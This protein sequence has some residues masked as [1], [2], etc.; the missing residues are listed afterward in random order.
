MKIIEVYL[1]YKHRQV[2]CESFVYF[3]AA[4]LACE[5][6]VCLCGYDVFLERGIQLV[7]VS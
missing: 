6:C 5:P 3:R 1:Y 7:L 2:C 4:E